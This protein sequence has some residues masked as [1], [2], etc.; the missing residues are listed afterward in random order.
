MLL[1]RLYNNHWNSEGLEQDFTMRLHP[2][3]LASK[4]EVRHK[5]LNIFVG[6]SYAFRPMLNYLKYNVNKKNK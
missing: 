2:Y 6:S 1:A 5:D 4:L 3:S